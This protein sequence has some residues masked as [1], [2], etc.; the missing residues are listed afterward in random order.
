[1]SEVGEALF[2]WVREMTGEVPGVFR[3]SRLCFLLRKSFCFV[4]EG[5]CGCAKREGREGE[6][7][8]RFS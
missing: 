5:R 3:F 6:M 4:S 7:G 8:Q 2:G 1:M